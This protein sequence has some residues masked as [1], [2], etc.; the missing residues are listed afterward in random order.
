M[1]TNT[2]NYNF[3]KPLVNDPTDQ[4]V[5][6]GYL[7]NN[8]DSVDA[9]MRS[10]ENS[11][12]GSAAPTSAQAGTS[13]LNNSADP[14][15]LSIYDGAQWVPILNIN[16]DTHTAI[17]AGAGF[18]AGD[19]KFSAQSANHGDWILCDGSSYST[20]TYPN[21]FA[22]ISY[23][24]GGSGAN[25]NVP[26][27]RSRVAGAIGQGSGLSNRTLGEAVGVE[28]TTNVPEHTH[29]LGGYQP[30][31]SDQ[32]SGSALSSPYLRTFST[33]SGQ[34]FSAG[35]TGGTTGYNPNIIETV[36]VTP[37]SL[38]QPTL[39]VGNYFIYGG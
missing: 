23:N 2:T 29:G 15:V 34:I 16:P 37:F 33:Q 31:G 3:Y 32:E 30:P 38:M 7:N 4:D 11:N 35:T 36:G 14:W 13:W 20:A 1:P 18:Y 28:S 26:D 17:I 12:I 21:L 39:F 6:G 25:F 5:W 9:I 22:Q 8:F 19:M 27:M 10:V 24:F